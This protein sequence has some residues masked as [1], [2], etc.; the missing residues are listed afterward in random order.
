MLWVIKI[1]TTLINVGISH[2]SLYSV[3]FHCTLNYKFK[4][5]LSLLELLQ[6]WLLTS[7]SFFSAGNKRKV[8]VLQKNFP[9]KNWPKKRS[10]FLGQ[11]SRCWTPVSRIWREF[12]L[13]IRKMIMSSWHKWQK[14]FLAAS[15]LRLLWNTALKERRPFLWARSWFFLETMS[16]SPPLSTG[17]WVSNCATW[18]ETPTYTGNAVKILENFKLL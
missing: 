9:P 15:R 6:N 10:G 1:S 3:I 5:T 16:R 7:A 17:N 13:Q 14:S 2:V 8:T 11:L 18:G 4:Q 12:L